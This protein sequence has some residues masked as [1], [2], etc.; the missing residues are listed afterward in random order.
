MAIDKI[1]KAHIFVHNDDYVKFIS[2][3]KQLSIVELMQEEHLKTSDFF[4]DY[5][6]DEVRDIVNKIEFVLNILKKY[7]SI[8]EFRLL[9]DNYKIQTKREIL[10][11]V[12]NTYTLLDSA[13]KKI[14]SYDTEIQLLEN[15]K[16][17][18]K[19]YKTFDADLMVLYSLK[20][21]K[22]FFCK[23]NSSKFEKFLSAIKN[24][25]NTEILWYNKEKLNTYFFCLYQNEPFFEI[26]N[27]IKTY[28]VEVVEIDKDIK[29]PT[30]S[31]EITFIEQKI[32]ENNQLK[33][34]LMSNISEVYQK[35]ITQIL[36]SYKNVLELNDYFIAQKNFA[37]TSKT[38]IINCWLPLMYLKKFETFVQKFENISF[39]LT[40][41]S[42]NEE[43][44]IVLKNKPSMEPYEFVT[45]LY[46]YP[47]QTNIDPTSLLAPFFT[48][49]FGLCMSDVIYGFL[50]FLTWF[51]IR[52]KIANFGKL[53]QLFSLLKYLGIGTI[54]GGIF[55]D[56]FLGFTVLRK[57]SGTER[58]VLF[59]PLN[60]PIDFLKFSFLLGL[61]HIIFGMTIKF[62]QSVKIK[63][64][65]A[66]VETFLWKILLLSLVPSVYQLIFAQQ[67]SQEIY[68]I[69]LKVAFWTTIVMIIVLSR[70]T[71]NIFLKPFSAL[72]KLY[73][74]V[75]YF[76]DI[77]S[78]ARI[79]ALSLAG[80]AISQTIN[81]LSATTWNIKFV[82]P[83][84]SV[85]IFLCG[86]SFNFAVN[87]LG[88]FVH[89]ARL[90]YLEFFSKFFEGGGRPI[91]YFSPIKQIV[92]S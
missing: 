60:K 55:L 76:S 79:L 30:I 40:N 27:I 53:G 63:D 19:H 35:F 89:S 14:K 16:D 90:Q 22:H 18:L 45:T 62:Y 81:L 57:Y 80:A 51:L 3:L 61:V 47:K 7:L 83:I 41:P 50:L 33:S 34:V 4:D 10:D 72:F 84:I 74:I 68:S 75:G 64:F 73:S 66:S 46:S 71:K 21:V 20:Q 58:V 24:V 42:P 85:I 70:D 67:V 2:G 49:F 91:K 37:H 31:E 52:K 28:N 87:C 48:L 77:F 92:K 29:F 26:D 69:S 36:S 11:L 78:Y 23:I 39:L 9:S 15:K 88:A 65:W 12:N 38:K 13:D 5:S 17:V 54:F 82:G 56:S 8:K 6:Y 44:P 43:V 32:Y 86:H 25:K 1:K 59:D